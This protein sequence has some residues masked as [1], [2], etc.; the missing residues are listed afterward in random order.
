MEEPK[1]ATNA[2]N[3]MVLLDQNRFRGRHRSGH[4]GTP[5]LKKAF[6]EKLWMADRP[7]PQQQ[8]RQRE[9][10]QDINNPAYNPFGHGHSLAS[11]PVCNLNIG[12][13]ISTDTDIAQ[14]SR[15]F[16]PLD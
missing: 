3:Q 6:R 15:R 14:L 13:T 4:G 16:F 9:S 5:I 11:K 2:K 1:K 10:N 12:I 7:E 8:C